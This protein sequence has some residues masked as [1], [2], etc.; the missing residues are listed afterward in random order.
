MMNEPFYISTSTNNKYSGLLL[1]PVI[2]ISG[3]EKTMTT[4]IKMSRILLPN[5]INVTRNINEKFQSNHKV[6]LNYSIRLYYDLRKVGV[7]M[8]QHCI[9][10]NPEFLAPPFMICS[11]LS[12]LLNAKSMINKLATIPLNPNLIFYPLRI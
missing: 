8:T 5:N 6:K 12:L 10:Q 9:S 1:S 3:E 11:K 4:A 2:C 7:S